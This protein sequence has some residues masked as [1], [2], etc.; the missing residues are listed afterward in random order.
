MKDLEARVSL[1]SR[2]RAIEEELHV[3]PTFLDDRQCQSVPVCCLISLDLWTSQAEALFKGVHISQ[4]DGDAH[5]PGLNFKSTQ[6]FIHSQDAW[7]STLCQNWRLSLDLE[8]LTYHLVRKFS[9][10]APQPHLW[11][12]VF[13]LGHISGRPERAM[14]IIS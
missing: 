4:S 8:A 3:S 12:R 11:R 7:H 6:S 13:L 5:T 9:D 2:R 10:D 1:V 14:I